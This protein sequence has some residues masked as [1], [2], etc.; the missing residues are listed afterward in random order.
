MKMFKLIEKD[1]GQEHELA[2]GELTDIVTYL[3]ENESVMNWVHDEDPDI[4]L[5]DLTVIE[6]LTDLQSELK[7]IDLSWW[8]LEV[9]EVEVETIF[10]KRDYQKNYLIKVTNREGSPHY[11]DG[12]NWQPINVNN[13]FMEDITK[14]WKDKTVLD[15]HQS[16]LGLFSL[17]QLE[18]QKILLLDRG[19]DHLPEFWEVD[20]T[21]IKEAIKQLLYL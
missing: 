13:T 1:H 17:Y 19:L 15:S 21:D 14:L 16:S 10:K 18:D 11:W 5:P 3:K 4:E 20:Q 9:E 12:Q 6:D 7:K 2:R 8:T